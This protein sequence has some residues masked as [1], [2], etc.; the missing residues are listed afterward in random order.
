MSV[1]I[2]GNGTITGAH[3]NKRIDKFT[4]SGTW[5][6]PAGV[7]YAIAYMM[8]GGG[9]SGQTGSGGQGGTSSVAF[10]S[11]T[12]SSPGMQAGGSRHVNTYVHGKK[13]GVNNIG[14]GAVHVGDG[15][16]GDSNSAPAPAGVFLVGGGTVT[17]GGS[18]AV[19]VGAGGSA[20]I[21]GDT[22]GSGYV[23]IEYY[24]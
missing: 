15:S 22:G 12:V 20:G 16:G 3:L 5:T 19:T 11:G 4:A 13:A 2:S 7:T 8:G 23:Y 1:S 10:P 21:S 6:V 14:Q 24:V 18:V 9:G 17:P